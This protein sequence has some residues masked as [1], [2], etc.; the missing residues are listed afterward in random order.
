MTYEENKKLIDAANLLKDYCRMNLKYGK[1]FK[2]NGCDCPFAIG[3]YI[4]AIGD[5]SPNSWV[6]PKLTR[7]TPEDIALAK[8][9]KAVGAKVIYKTLGIVYWATDDV[10]DVGNLPNESFKSIKDC[11]SFSIEYIIKEAEEV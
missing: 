2:Y 4:C 6:V 9:L 11:E 8:S 7:W 3:D 1:N 5:P 10:N